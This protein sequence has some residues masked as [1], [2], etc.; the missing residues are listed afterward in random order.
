[1]IPVDNEAV[2]CD[3]LRSR[4]GHMAGYVSVSADTLALPNQKVAFSSLTAQV[5]KW[6]L[7]FQT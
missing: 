5:L 1:M 7:S 6:R 3:K 4:S 2:Y